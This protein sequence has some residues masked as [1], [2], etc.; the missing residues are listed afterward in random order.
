MY[1]I[2]LRPYWR[3]KVDGQVVWVNGAQTNEGDKAPARKTL[4]P[5]F[6]EHS[7]AISRLDVDIGIDKVQICTFDISGEE[8]ALVGLKLFPRGKLIEVEIGYADTEDDVTRVFKGYIMNMAPSP[9]YPAIISVYADSSLYKARELTLRETSVDGTAIQS[10]ETAFKLE[11]VGMTFKNLSILE[12]EVAK[13]IDP[14]SAI[15][16]NLLHEFQAWCA[17][18]GVHFIDLMD[19]EEIGVFFPASINDLP[20]F[21]DRK[22]SHKHWELAMRGSK[23]AL[24]IAAVL[25]HWLPT[26]DYVDAPHQISGV[27]F[28]PRPDSDEPEPHFITYPEV[29][30]DL[31]EGEEVRRWGVG[32]LGVFRTAEEAKKNLKAIFESRTWFSVT[33]TFQLLAGLPILPLDTITAVNGFIGMEGLGFYD[34]PYRVTQVH[35]IFDASG[36]RVSGRVRGGV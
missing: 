36:W 10:F 9:A 18:A 30:P 34:E 23:D 15:V 7:A 1:T 19:N 27:W 17:D 14:G 6:V 32:G 22:R 33:G 16:G 26:V 2:G 8:A 5:E 3:L 13:V 24:D 12:D 29:A 20:L 21:N 35:H 25:S 11:G 31:E 4:A 28:E